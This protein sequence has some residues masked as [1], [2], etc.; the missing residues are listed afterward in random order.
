MRTIDNS[1]AHSS[2]EFDKQVIR[3][4]P[5]YEVFHKQTVDLVKVLCPSPSLWLD[6][7][8]GTGSMFLNTVEMF[9]STHFV[10]SDP[11]EAM[12]DLTRTNLGKTQNK[13]ISILDPCSTQEISWQGK[14]FDIITAIM[15]HHYLSVEE[16]ITASQKCLDLLCNGG[17]Y[18][19][20]ETIK[21][22]SLKATD[23]GLTRW[24]EFQMSKGKST[25]EVNKHLSRYGTEL[26]PITINEH[27]E[28][29]RNCGFK[30]VELF[31]YSYLQAGFYA[32]K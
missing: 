26:K 12:T 15:V 9:N 18:I 29:L 6:T 30:T 24:K 2:Q 7:G 21:P 20:F 32:I 17:V 8:C 28:I 10:F 19:S 25:E 16:R 13:K 5:F 27:I 1:T 11:A 31:W 4:I 14:P 23:T 3:T 22:G